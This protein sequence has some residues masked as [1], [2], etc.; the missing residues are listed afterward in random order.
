MK[1]RSVIPMRI[2][3]IGYIIMS[4]FLFS[5]GI[6]FISQPDIS[7]QFIG[8]ILGIVLILF[9]CIK[10]VGYFS[11]DLFRLAF[12][13]DLQFGILIIV[14]GLVLFLKPSEVINLFFAAM[15]FAILAD[16]LFKFQIA[17]DSKKFGIGKWWGILAL[18]IFAAGFA[19]VL[20]FKPNVSTK[21]LVSLL[22][23]T[24][25][26]M[27]CMN[28]FVAI[29]TVKIIKHQYPDYIEVD[30]FEMEDENK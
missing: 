18:A 24:L 9:G 5:L 27:G 11:R 19:L 23:L 1:L 4:L 20:I 14:L 17:L 6:L 3:K 16:S 10:L 28:L 29:T 2:A 22:G 30:Y 21:V 8:K 7:V 26:A 15:G 13:Y 25:I 12:Q